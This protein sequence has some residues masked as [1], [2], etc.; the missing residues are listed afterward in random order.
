[1]NFL[2]AYYAMGWV[3]QGLSFAF[4]PE[5]VRPPLITMMLLWPVIIF[6]TILCVIILKI[7]DSIPSAK[8]SQYLWRKE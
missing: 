1:M 6:A 5:H 4:V 3:S 8:K 2:I 7:E